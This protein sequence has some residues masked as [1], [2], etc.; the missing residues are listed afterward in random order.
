[1][2]LFLPILLAALLAGCLSVPTPPQEVYYR[3]E[4]PAAAA[5]GVFTP[6]VVVMPFSAPGVYAERPLLWARGSALRQYYRHFWAESPGLELHGA[7]VDSLRASG[8][9]EVYTAGNRVR[10]DVSVQPAIRQMELQTEGGRRAVLS[11]EFL[12][13]DRDGRPLR[14]LVVNG[15]RPLP[16]DSAPEA[17][18]A[19]VTQLAGEAFAKLAGELWG[20]Q[21]ALANGGEPAAP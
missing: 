18:V 20:L 7:L 12:V 2:K 5:L 4:P 17:Y 11:L 8:A 14:N 13:N 21:P 10:G 3:L 19:A 16:A 9:T 15:Q 6:R 1:M